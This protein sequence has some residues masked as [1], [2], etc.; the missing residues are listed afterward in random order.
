MTKALSSRERM[1]KAIC[2]READRVP[3]CFM[4]FATL[5]DKCKDRYEFVEKQLEM[6]LDATVE[7]PM[8]P[9]EVQIEHA[10]LSGLP[11]PYHP[12]V[13]VKEWCED[14][15]TEI[16]PILHKEYHTPAG[17]LAT[18]VNKTDDWPYDDHVPFFDDYLIPRSRKYL[19]ENQIDLKALRYLLIPP[20]AT[21]IRDFREK[22][23]IA[24]KFAEQH[25]LLVTSSRGV[26]IEAACWLCGIHNLILYAMDDEALVGE[27]AE[28]L[29]DWNRQRMELFLDEGVHLFIRRGWYEG[30]DFWSPSLFRKFM[31]PYLAKEIEMA[32]QA[33]AYFGYIMTS[34]SMP[35]LDMFLELGLDILIGIDPIQGKGTDMALMKEKVGGKI[36]LWGGVNGFITVESGSR[37]EAKEA[38]YNA[39]KTLAP[40]GGFI[41]SPVDNVRDTSEKTWQNVYAM[42]EAWEEMREYPIK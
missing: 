7:L 35:L 3:C 8:G 34:G 42:I 33:G 2:N 22:S 28:M 39:I 14:V 19:V 24:K 16:Y 26:G 12:Q 21:D 37:T 31:F 11:V 25:G 17:I 20:T 1:L 27:L 15:P 9:L 6:G 32:H 18:E 13:Q 40:G 36:C 29:Y 38:V 23:N 5:R 4:I 30:T 41:L 10:D